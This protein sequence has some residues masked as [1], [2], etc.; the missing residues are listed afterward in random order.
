MGNLEYPVFS[1]NNF[2]LILVLLKE[3][4]FVNLGGASLRVSAAGLF[5]YVCTYLLTYIF[6]ILISTSTI[7]SF[8]IGRLPCKVDIS[9]F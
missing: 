2:D 4:V 9:A 7:F 3:P 1:G 5:K 8:S 6:D